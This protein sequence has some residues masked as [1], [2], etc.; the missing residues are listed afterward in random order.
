MGG[1]GSG[2]AFHERQP[3]SPRWLPLAL[4]TEVDGERLR[5][6]TARGGRWREVALADIERTEAVRLGVVAWP[7]GYKLAFGGE[8]TYYSTSGRGV[9]L[10]LRSGRVLTLGTRDPEGLRRALQPP[11]DG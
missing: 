2:M 5:F 9:R 1:V 8:E 11:S 7:A 10:H 3:A 6:R 4:E